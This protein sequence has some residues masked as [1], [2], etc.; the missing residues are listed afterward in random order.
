LSAPA[1]PPSSELAVSSARRSDGTKP[2]FALLVASVC[3][4][5]YIPIA[6]GTFGSLA[7]LVLVMLPARIAATANLWGQP[8]D[9]VLLVQVFL[10]AVIAA[11]GVWSADRSAAFWHE[12]DP[13]RVVIDEVSGQHLAVLLGVAVPLWRKQVQ[14]ANGM[15]GPHSV[16]NWKYLVVGFILFRVFDIWKPFPVRQAESLPGGW[17]IMTDDWAA[18][19]YAA[20]GLWIARAVGL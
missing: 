4:L 16:L 17:G 5:G 18:G 3:G 6:P 14:M 15:P 20:M 19:V 11:V 13:Q 10:A 12:R 8:I 2:V 7:G 9:L 1:E